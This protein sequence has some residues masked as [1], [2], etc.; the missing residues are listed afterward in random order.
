MSKHAALL[1]MAIPLWLGCQRASANKPGDAAHPGVSATE[2]KIGQTMPYS[3]PASAYGSIG[4]AHAAYFTMINEQGGI[5]GRKLQLISLDD[6]YSPPKTVEQ[7]RRMIEN[8]NVAFIFNVVGTAPNSAIQKYLNERG[9]PQ[10]FVA[11]GADKWNDPEH[12]KWTMGWQPSY[13]I[14]A[15]IY[16]KHIDATKPEARVCLLYQND[17]FGKD[18]LSGLQ[19]FFGPAFA[20][21][22][23]R[24][25]SYEVTDPSVDSQLVDLHAAGCDT[26]VTAATPKFA[27]Q[28]IRKVYDLGWK[29]LHYLSNVSAS[30]GTVMKRVG[31]EKGVGIITGAYLKD[32]SDPAFKDD[33]GVKQWRAFMD[34]YL[35]DAD[36]L[37][38]NFIYAYAVDETLVHVLERCGSDLSRENIL[39]RAASIQDFKPS[40]AL[41]GTELDTSSGDYSLFSEMQLARFNG[42]SY[43]RFGEMMSGE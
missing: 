42:E 8:D 26:L 43:V 33:P 30:I 9:V 22:V 7:T 41:P 18:Y 19:D 40:L 37:D 11:S 1:V 28:A 14:E 25:A 17:D 2:I 38:A 23:L 21:K 4:K 3:G 39:A 27:A 29:P 31:V 12:H 35:P 13:R 24:T 15:R 16:A 5:N 20:T 34:K 36:P 6:G 10:L 32:V